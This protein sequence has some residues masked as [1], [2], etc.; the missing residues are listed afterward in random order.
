MLITY[1]LVDTFEFYC[2]LS[3]HKT[4]TT[5]QASKLFRAIHSSIASFLIYFT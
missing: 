3:T 2:S 4:S 1:Y 5:E